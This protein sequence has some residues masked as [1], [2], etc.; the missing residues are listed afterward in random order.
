[1]SSSW[2]PT[3]SRAPSLLEDPRIPSG[4]WCAAASPARCSGSPLTLPQAKRYN[5]TNTYSNYSSILTY[6]HHGY[7]DYSDL[8]D[9][10]ED[11]YT[12]VESDAGDIL[13][14]NLLDESMRTAFSLA[15][16]TPQTDMLRQAVDWWD[17]GKCCLAAYDLG[18]DHPC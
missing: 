4:L 17:W 12:T 9:E 13:T 6:D 10:W 2:A 16:W 1:M 8:L 7:R 15:E 14:Q 18:H 11:K 3:G 5:L